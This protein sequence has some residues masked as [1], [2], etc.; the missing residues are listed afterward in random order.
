MLRD[1][2]QEPGALS[3]ELVIECIRWK[4][5]PPLFR[6]NV[7]CL[8]QEWLAIALLLTPEA[9][10]IFHD[11]VETED[12]QYNEDLEMHFYPCP[13]EGNFSIT[14]EDLENGEDMAMFPDCSLIIKVIYDKD[15][16]MCGETIPAPFTNKVLVNAEEDFKNLCRSHCS[17]AVS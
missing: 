16:F 15:Q 9:V 7:T 17:Q 12:F 1:L 2:H 5:P 10:V 13:C 11:K 4:N 3:Q 6:D 8:S 14:K